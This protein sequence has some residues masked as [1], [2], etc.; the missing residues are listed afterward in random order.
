MNRSRV[1][2]QNSYFSRELFVARTR[3][4]FHFNYFS[5]QSRAWPWNEFYGSSLCILIEYTLN[6][7]LVQKSPSSQ[8]QHCLDVSLALQ[9][10]LSVYINQTKSQLSGIVPK[11]HRSYGSWIVNWISL[12][13]PCNEIDRRN[14]KY[15]SMQKRSP[16]TA[17]TWIS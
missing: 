4:T 15:L 17:R 8:S 3:L 12:Q 9:T 6:D 11:R 7:E 13:N 1:R 14:A 10:S 2:K 5:T 16:K